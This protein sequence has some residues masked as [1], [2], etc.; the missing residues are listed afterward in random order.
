MTNQDGSSVMLELN[1]WTFTVLVASGKIYFFLQW[2][3][4]ETQ[5]MRRSQLSF[6][7]YL[8]YLCNSHL[9]QIQLFRKVSAK[10]LSR[11]KQNKIL[12]K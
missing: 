6:V 12:K 3:F 7:P 10:N 9:C 2:L 11:F 1:L 8:V 5:V 4:L